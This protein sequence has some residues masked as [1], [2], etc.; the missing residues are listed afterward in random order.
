MAKTHETSLICTDPASVGTRLDKYLFAQFPDYSRA[1]FQ[2]LIDEGLVT[3]NQHPAKSSYPLKASDQ[4]TITFRTKEYNLAPAPVTFGIVDEQADFVVVNKPAGL[5]VH[6]SP[7]MPDEVT[8]V[9]GLLHR[10]KEINEFEEKERPGIVHRID[11]N[12]SGLLIIARNQ[13]AQKELSE[14]FKNRQMHKTYL[15]L[16]S[17]HP[18]RSGSID[19]PI[20]RH[21]IERHKMTTFG[22]EPREALTNYNVLVYYDDCSLVAAR[23]I[24]GRTH[25]IRVHFASQGHGLIGDAVYG[26]SSKLIARQALHAWKLSFDWR[27]KTYNYVCPVPD[28]FKR[29]LQA[30]TQ[31]K[32]D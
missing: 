8:L 9:N 16:A 27:G 26:K 7:S 29:C 17:K 22:I 18:D 14:M 10:F 31:Q 11:K 6:P 28:D 4:I 2:E 5:S 19:L 15:L 3:V 12:T 1:Y 24:T 30:L 20:G 23:I 32:K 25:Q 21:A 13:K